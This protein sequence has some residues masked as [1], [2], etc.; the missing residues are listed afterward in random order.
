[1]Q[2]GQMTVFDV[3]DGTK[4]FTIPKYQRA[5]AWNERQLKDFVDDLENQKDGKAYFLGTIL[6]QVQQDDGFFKRIDIVDGQQRITTVIIFMK[7]LLDKLSEYGQD[8]TLLRET[9]LQRH[10]EYK[11]RVLDQDNDFFRSYILQDHPVNDDLITTPSQH[12]LLAAKTFL[13]KLLEP[14][15]LS[16]LQ[17]FQEKLRYTRVLSYAVDNTA[18]ATLIFETTNDRG[19]GLT[20]LEKTKSFLMYKAY[21]CH[22]HPDSHLDLMQE[23]FSQI[24]RDYEVIQDR[25]DEDTILQYH[26]I[27]FERWYSTREERGYYKYVQQIKEKV[28][29]LWC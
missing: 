26:F 16:E 12:R 13:N 21:L 23:R 15:S 22:D 3:F 27:A 8:T 1:M 24:Y 2:N 5:Y 4:I 25:I 6:F 28:N 18:D 17:A 11:L 7:L 19:K 14:F 20:N 29:N 9:Y 10:G